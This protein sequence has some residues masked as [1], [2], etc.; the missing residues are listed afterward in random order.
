MR[1]RLC[2]A[3]VLAVL[4]GFGSS[5]RALAHQ[6]HTSCRGGVSE[7]AKAGIAGETASSQAEGG[8]D[9]EV[10]AGHAALC[11]PK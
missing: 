3:A 8:L 11:Q 2:S 10:A 5:G 6:G 7:L 1:R 4:I 9:E